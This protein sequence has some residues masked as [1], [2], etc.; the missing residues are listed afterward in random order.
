MTREEEHAHARNLTEEES[1]PRRTV[2]P[3]PN[4]EI[5][6]LVVTTA[7]SLDPLIKSPVGTLSSTTCADGRDMY[8]RADGVGSTAQRRVT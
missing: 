4:S 6:H 3:N 2:G 1:E 7:T 8:S 5:G